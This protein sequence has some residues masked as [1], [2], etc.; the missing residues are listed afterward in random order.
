METDV[1]KEAGTVDSATQ[2]LGARCRQRIAGWWAAWKRRRARDDHAIAG[3]GG[4]GSGN[5]GN[6]GGGNGSS[7]EGLQDVSCCDKCGSEVAIGD[8]PYCPHGAM[9]H[10]MLGEFAPYW[11]EHVAPSGDPRGHYVTS[12]AQRWRLMRENNCHYAG[13]KVGMPRCEV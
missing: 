13:K 3:A 9:G 4:D 1:E 2:R 7:A 5:A 8:W 12:L 11:D 6:G 10:G